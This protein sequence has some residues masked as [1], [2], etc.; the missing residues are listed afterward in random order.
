MLINLINFSDKLD[1]QR[2][3]FLHERQVNFIICL[4]NP[5]VIMVSR[6]SSSTN[7]F[8]WDIISNFASVN[9]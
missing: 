3:S 5:V 1:N 2:M 7:V 6:L 8:V 9:H 4:N